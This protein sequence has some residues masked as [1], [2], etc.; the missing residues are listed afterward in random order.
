M[1]QVLQVL[2]VIVSPIREALSSLATYRSFDIHSSPS[3]I[4]VDLHYLNKKISH[5]VHYYYCS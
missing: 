5:S 3:V 1:F 4:H 2:L